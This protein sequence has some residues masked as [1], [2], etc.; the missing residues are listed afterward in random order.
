[1]RLRERFFGDFE[2]TSN[3]NYE[4]VWAE[5]AKDADHT[6]HNCESVNSV[7]DRA[8]EFVCS[9]ESSLDPGHVVL[10]VAHGDVCQILET[11]FLGIDGASHRTATEHLDTATLRRLELGPSS[12]RAR[13]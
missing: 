1:M 3:E 4:R 13:V 9:V 5:D 10:L 6:K 2:G 12:T 7:I 8:S 11:A